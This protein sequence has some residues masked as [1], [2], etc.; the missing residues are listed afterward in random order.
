M[1]NGRLNAAEYEELNTALKSIESTTENLLRRLENDGKKLSNDLLTAELDAIYK[2]HKDTKSIDTDNLLHF[3]EKFISMCDRKPLTIKGY[4]QT[5]RELR[6]YS[7][8]KNKL[9]TFDAIDLDFYLDFVDFLTAK[10]YAPNTI[11]TR[12]KDLKMLMNEAYDRGLHANLD[13]K[14]K[15][16]K[17]PNEET[18]SVYLNNDELSK[19]YNLKLGN[20][21]KLEKVRDLFMIGCYT[22]LRFSDLS[23]LTAGNINEDGTITIKTIK[24]EHTVV[25]PLH[26]IVKLILEKY[27][28]E[29]PKVPSNQKFNEY[30]K[31]VAKRA[32]INEPIY[33][34]KKKGDLSYKETVY[35]WEIVTSHTA[36]RS[37]ATNA[38]IA[39]VP[40]IS[41]M[42]I[43]GHKTES[44]FMKYIKISAKENALKLRAHSF[45]NPMVINK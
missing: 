9:L 43:T 15:R 25:I 19:I 39:G 44:S 23:Q 1:K 11:G 29:L 30:I 22:G 45:F 32:E 38:Y 18:F 3:V 21:K 36:R 13:F 6:D 33:L 17:K 5:L 28:Y 4:R 40:T 31:E 41:I 24:T 34:D 16:F 12:I 14:K 2:G 42:K 8:K 7:T 20:T 35:K 27:N 37:F 10:E 26:S